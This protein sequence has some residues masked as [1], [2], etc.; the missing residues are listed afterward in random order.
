MMLKHSNELQTTFTDMELDKLLDAYAIDPHS[1]TLFERIIASAPQI[2]VW[3]QLH[4]WFGN[5]TIS[6]G[7][8]GLVS[9]LAGAFCFAVVINAW[10]PANEINGADFIDDGQYWLSQ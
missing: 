3:Q 10:Q 2:S 7:S 5:R 8:I 4:V 1:D 9:A 6:I